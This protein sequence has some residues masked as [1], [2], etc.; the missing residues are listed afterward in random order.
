MAEKKYLGKVLEAERD[1]IRRLYERKGALTE[2]LASLAGTVS[3]PGKSDLYE[4]IVDDLATT[5][6]KYSAWFGRMKNKYAW[7]DIPG[8][9]WRIDFETCDVYLEGQKPRCDCG[10][11]H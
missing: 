8:M 5:G 6:N 3:Q 1:E 2:L 9:I 7:D 11:E 4:K 10:D